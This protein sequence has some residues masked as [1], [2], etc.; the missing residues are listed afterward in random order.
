MEILSPSVIIFIFGGDID[1]P[2]QEAAGNHRNVRNIFSY[3]RSLCIFQH[4]V[5]RILLRE[6]L[7]FR[8]AQCKHCTE[9]Q[10][11]MILSWRPFD[12]LRTGIPAF[13]SIT[14]GR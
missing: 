3:I 9:E 14:R 6:G 8:F 11:R 13:M 4:K 10:I 2:L 5:F 1:D 12:K 7:I